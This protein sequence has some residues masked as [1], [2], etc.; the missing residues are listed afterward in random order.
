MVYK[1]E[2]EG[3]ILGMS[4]ERMWLRR[5][6]TYLEEEN[7][8]FSRFTCIVGPNGCGKSNLID[9]LLFLLGSELGEIRGSIECRGGTGSIYVE[10]QYREKKGSIITL[11]REIRNSTSIYLM[12]N[13]RVTYKEYE[14]YLE[15][16]SILIRHKNF[17][18]SQHDTMLKVPKELT[19]FIDQVSGSTS[20]KEEYV[21][22]KTHREDLQKRYTQSLEKKKCAKSGLQEYLEVKEMMNRHMK[23]SEKKRYIQAVTFLRKRQEVVERKNEVNKKVMQIKKETNELE[24]EEIE[25]KISEIQ[26]Q[27]IRKRAERASLLRKQKDKK[28][29]DNEE[30]LELERKEEERNK[31]EEMLRE[32]KGEAEA[33]IEECNWEIKKIKKLSLEKT[34]CLSE[35][36]KD[37]LLKAVRDIQKLEQNKEILQKKMKIVELERTIKEREAIEKEE[38]KQKEHKPQQNTMLPSLNNE[39]LSVLKQ[40]AWHTSQKKETKAASQLNYYINQLKKNMPQIIGRIEDLVYVEDVRYKKALYA[41]IHGKRNTVIIDEEKNLTPILNGLSRAVSGRVTLLLLSRINRTYTHPSTTSQNEYINNGYINWK[42]ILRIDSKVKE[43]EKL[44]QYICG[45]ALLYTEESPPTL[46]GRKIVTIDGIVISA[47]GSIRKHKAPED[48]EEQR[49]LETRKEFLLESIAK[50]S[51][52]EKREKENEES[53]VPSETL[54]LMI[55]EHEAS[56]QHLS[57]AQEEIR[58]R[59]QEIIRISS[60]PEELIHQAI[61]QGIYDTKAAQKKIQVLEER[62][63]RWSK[64]LEEIKISEHAIASHLSQLPSAQKDTPIKKQNEQSLRDVQSRIEEYE[65]LLSSLVEKMNSSQTVE[66]KILQEQLFSLNEEQEEIEQNMVE[67]GI[68]PQ[69]QIKMQP[70]IQISEE[71]LNEI[72]KEMKEISEFLRGRKAVAETEELYNKTEEEVEEV[73]RELTQVEASFQ[74]IQKERT[75]LFLNIFD[76]L[77]KEI[78]RNYSQLMN[79]SEETVKA[80]LGLENSR[81]PYLGRTCLYAITTGKTFR[82]AKYLS[83]GERTMAAL[84]LLLS[85]HTIIPSPFYIFDEVDSALDKEKIFS[86]CSSLQ[87]ISSQFIGVTHRIEFFERAETLLGVAKPPQ[88]YSQIFTLRL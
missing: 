85:I 3:K 33:Q 31:E 55:K 13:E 61:S 35:E 6:K 22:I 43:K 26:L 83:G 24:K 72:S 16:E 67:E 49:T 77:N 14:K 7:V 69:E 50:E 36:E 51:R 28:I 65:H 52:E 54:L 60:I 12:N 79:L 11:R 53:F 23:L 8:L 71:V 64:A 2:E 17:L 70:N 58:E 32:R 29:N 42:N 48:A 63:K 56:V 5:F 1:K 76:A 34:K 10:A 39:L 57:E 82:E 86:L 27:L 15:S 68:L 73:K 45:E 30:A 37:L 74:N 40:L 80:H 66:L 59:K 4:L 88:G 75:T 25:K 44:I 47:T 84:A 81:E 9:G 21:R 62:I 20:L 87:G 46:L 41:L 18:I 19:K 38:A 78:S